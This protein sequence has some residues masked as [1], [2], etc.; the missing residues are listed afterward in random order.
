MNPNQVKLSKPSLLHTSADNGALDS[1]FLFGRTFPVV[2]RIGIGAFSY[3][4]L[5]KNVE[6]VDMFPPLVAVKRMFFPISDVESAH[7]EMEL[8]ESLKGLRHIVRY[9][10]GEVG[11]SKGKVCVSLVFEYCPGSLINTLT[12]HQQRMKLMSE[13]VIIEL[14]C[15]VASALSYLHAMSPPVAHRD[16]KAENILVGTDGEFKLC[17]FGSSTRT[18]FLCRSRKEAQFAVDEIERKTTIAYRAPEMADC[19]QKHRIDEQ[20][21]VWALGVLVYHCMYLKFPFEETNL[22]ILN[23][24]VEFPVPKLIGQPYSDDLVLF[25]KRCLIKNPAERWNVFEMIGFL[26]D[27]KQHFLW[28]SFPGV[29]SFPFLVPVKPEGWLPQPAVELG[30]E[31]DINAPIK[32]NLF[33][34]LKWQPAAETVMTTGDPVPPAQAKPDCA[35][36]ASSSVDEQRS[37]TQRPE[38]TAPQVAR[39][40]TLDDLF[41]WAPAVSSGGVVAEV[42]PPLNSLDAFFLPA[43][44][45]SSPPFEGQAATADPFAKLFE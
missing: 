4:Y 38:V 15:S 18:A 42:K 27:K 6:N 33:T 31:E 45:V 13:A 20:V 39:G 26:K 40:S 23:A 11:R 8:L 30:E 21:D 43:P 14:I 10:E 1:I 41:G 44:H 3:V 37:V 36:V 32:G 17:D 19:W 28:Q 25:V 34:M 24:T 12:L 16:V 2:Q 5:C 29:L 35:I 9:H 22:A 7:Y